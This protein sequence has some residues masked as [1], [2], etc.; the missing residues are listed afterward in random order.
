M[1]AFH[2]HQGSVA[3][4][5]RENVDTDA[6]IPKQFLKSIKRTGY[7]PNAFFDW[8]YTSAGGLNPDFDLNHPRLG[9]FI[10]YISPHIEWSV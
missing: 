6:I 2:V 8:R 7:G 10:Y 3:P 4:I 9:R 1:Q 5:D